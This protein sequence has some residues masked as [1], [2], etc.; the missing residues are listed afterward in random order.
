MYVSSQTPKRQILIDVLKNIFSYFNEFD[1]N[2]F[3]ET[4][5]KIKR[6][7]Q[8]FYASG[9]QTLSPFV[10]IESKFDAKHL[11]MGLKRGW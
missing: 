7:N 9:N 8:A 6:N 11:K 2:I 3:S 1:Y 4:F 10:K 5:S